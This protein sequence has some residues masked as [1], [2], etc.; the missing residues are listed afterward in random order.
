MDQNNISIS[1]SKKRLVSRLI[2]L[3]IF[4]WLTY[5][6]Y[7]SSEMFG[8]IAGTVIWVLWLFADFGDLGRL[9]SR[10]DSNKITITEFF[11]VDTISRYVL[12]LYFMLMILV[13]ELNNGDP[14][15][16][17]DTPFI[18]LSFFIFGAFIF[19][20]MYRLEV[21]KIEM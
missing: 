1:R 8:V 18:P 10:P 3:T 14:Y 21:Q 5:F 16:G 6:L 12:V 13:F 17:H 9:K 20:K 7:I 4:V 11:K 19:W 2:A 15:K